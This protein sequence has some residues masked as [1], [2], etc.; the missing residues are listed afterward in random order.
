MEAGGASPTL[1]MYGVLPLVCIKHTT[2]AN[3]G[4]G[5]CLQGGPAKQIADVQ[6]GFAV[7]CVNDPSFP[8]ADCR[9]AVPWHALYMSI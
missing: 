1:E 6:C 4:E 2:I 7:V 8:R 9:A 3:E 5:I